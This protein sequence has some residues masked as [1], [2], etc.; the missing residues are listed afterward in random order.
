MHDLR[1][2]LTQSGTQSRSGGQS[3]SCCLEISFSQTFLFSL[4][5]QHRDYMGAWFPAKWSMPSCCLVL[6]SA[7]LEERG[8]QGIW[9]FFCSH[10]NAWLSCM[11]VRSASGKVETYVLKHPLPSQ[12]CVSALETMWG[13]EQSPSAEEEWGPTT[14]SK[15]PCQWTAEAPAVS[16][17]CWQ[18]NSSEKNN[19][20]AVNMGKALNIMEKYK[21]IYVRV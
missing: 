18:D 19:P 3:A 4:A 14:K 1:A 10:W 9:D 6:R 12:P 20:Q 5:Y 8:L 21:S 11:E 16:T 2:A 15:L 7:V 13:A 17:D